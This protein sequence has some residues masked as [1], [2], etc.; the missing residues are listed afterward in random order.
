MS[1][2]PCAAAKVKWISSSSP[3]KFISSSVG[4]TTRC[5]ACRRR[6]A[7][8][9]EL[10]QSSRYRLR[11]TGDT[12]P[13]EHQPFNLRLGLQQFLV[14]LDIG[15]SF[16]DRFERE[17]V[18]GGSRLVVQLICFHRPDKLPSRHVSPFNVELLPPGMLAADKVLPRRDHGLAH[19]PSVEPLLQTAKTVLNRVEAVKHRDV[20]F[21]HDLAPDG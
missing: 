10:E 6:L 8:R 18:I 16:A 11:A 15:E 21:C 5:P 19:L 17:T 1:V 9:S 3:D 4:R 14:P 13:L 7:K 12:S 2:R 20:I